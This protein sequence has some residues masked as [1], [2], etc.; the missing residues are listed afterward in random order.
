MTGEAEAQPEES[1][2]GAD[3]TRLVGDDLGFYRVWN[4]PKIQDTLTLL[5][6]KI[7]ARRTG[8]PPAPTVAPTVLL[9]G[10]AVGSE[11]ALETRIDEPPPVP[12]QGGFSREPL[13]AILERAGLKAVLQTQSSRPLSDSVFFGDESLVVLLANS[14]WKLEEA[15]DALA[16]SVRGLWTASRL[17]A[18]WRDQNDNG[19]TYSEMDGLTP[20]LVAARGKHLFIAN[21]AQPLLA[22]LGRMTAPASS[23]SSGYAAAFRHARE[24]GGYRRFMGQL[25]SLQIQR[26][27]ASRNRPPEFFSENVGSLSTALARVKDVLLRTEDRGSTVVQ[28]VTYELNP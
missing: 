5:E 13:R 12:L 3:L 23:S 24:S 10:G 17:G 28:T 11:A 25:D 1:S 26:Y 20:L 22:A 6:R 16:D 19:E 27:G 18:Q 7:L 21:A 15:R 4:A 8:T 9:G 2:I 14:D